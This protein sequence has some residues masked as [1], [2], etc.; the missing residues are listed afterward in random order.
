[1]ALPATMTHSS[2]RMAL[3]ADLLLLS[4]AVFWGSNFVFIKDAVER[5]SEA[6][7]PGAPDIVAGTL[8]YLVLRYVAATGVF[9]AVQPRSWLRAT[10]REWGMGSLLGAFY[11]TA[12]ILQTIGLQRTSPGVSGF[13]TGLSVAMVP[14]LY[15][16]VSRHSPGRWQIFGAVVATVG[17]TALSMQGDFTLSWGDSLTLAGAFFY[18]LHIMTTGFF[19]PKVRPQTLAVTQMAASTAALLVLTPVFVP[20][21]LDLPWQAWAAVGWTALSG[22]IYAFFIQSWAQRYTTSTHA[23]ILL[24]FESVFAA[25]AGI[26]F[27]MDSVTWRLL[28][29]G[30]LMLTGVLIVELMPSPQRAAPQVAGSADASAEGDGDESDAGPATG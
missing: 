25:L 26:L 9:A 8:L 7:R 12:L 14:F 2:R 6:V 17:L 24:G 20:I 5:T 18:A 10:R 30:S 1:M 27:G 28:L 16:A 11:L 3:V 13:I 23:A 29:G 4:V 21:T 19:A 22:T 15:W